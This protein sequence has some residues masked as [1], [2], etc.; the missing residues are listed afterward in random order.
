MP[1]SSPLKTVFNGF[2]FHSLI[3]IRQDLRSGI[4]LSQRKYVLD[5]LHESGQLACRPASTPIEANH[6]LADSEGE[7][8]SY[9]GQYRRLIGK[10]HPPRLSYDPFWDLSTTIGSS[11]KGTLNELPHSQIYW[12]RILSGFGL[13]PAKRISRVLL[14]ESTMGL[15]PYYTIRPQGRTCCPMGQVLMGFHIRLREMAGDFT[16][17]IV[18]T[19]FH[20]FFV[21][22]LLFTTLFK[23]SRRIFSRLNAL[24]W[25]LTAFI[26]LWSNPLLVLVLPIGKGCWVIWRRKWRATSSIPTLLIVLS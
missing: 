8:L 1:P 10:C 13:S 14:P 11:L 12:R 18:C 19:R 24:E 26:P 16:H 7:L 22:A 4:S 23:E 2:A 25:K 17:R 6:H 15:M 20:C 5:L 3:S 9:A 21:W